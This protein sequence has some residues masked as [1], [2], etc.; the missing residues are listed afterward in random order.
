[1]RLDSFPLGWRSIA[2]LWP[3]CERHEVEG[4][5]ADLLREFFWG[6]PWIL[7]VDAA[8][9]HSRIVS[10]LSFGLRRS[11]KGQTEGSAADLR[12][13][14][15]RHLSQPP[16]LQTADDDA[17]KEGGRARVRYTLPWASA[18]KRQVYPKYAF[19]QIFRC[20]GR[21]P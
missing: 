9:E 6:H 16:S 10:R 11:E 21:L 20:K 19:E 5:I 7:I 4:F 2:I 13:A 17:R 3:L 14:L 1:M 18:S 12:T 8:C 15:Q